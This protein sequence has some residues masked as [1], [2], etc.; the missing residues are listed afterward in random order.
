MSLS[1]AQKKAFRSIGHHLNPV[2]TVSENGVS[3]N[4]LAELSRALNDHELIKVKVASQDR[5]VRREII[6]ALCQISG[7]ELVQTIGKIAVLLRRARTP[8]P[9]LSNLLRHTH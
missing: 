6:E 7:A 5:E 1:Q 4:L 3:D 9:R 8:N 2:V